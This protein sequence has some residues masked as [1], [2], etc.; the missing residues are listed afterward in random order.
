[1]VRTDMQKRA[2]VYRGQLRKHLLDERNRSRLSGSEHST[3]RRL[4]QWLVLL[5]GH[6][7][8]E[9]PK[10]LLFGNDGDVIKLRIRNQLNGFLG[11]D[12]SGRRHQRA[13]DILLGMFEVRRVE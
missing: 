11:S 6:A 7:V 12:A 8:V 2:R 1:L 5:P 4:H 3:M 10:R 9:M 13:R